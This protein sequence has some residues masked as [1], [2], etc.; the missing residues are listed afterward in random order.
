MLV[1]RPSD[2]DRYDIDRKRTS[3]N[4]ATRVSERERRFE[5]PPPPRFDG[6]ITSPS[7]R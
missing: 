5:P 2:E 7:T 1:K 3:H 6:P 4:E